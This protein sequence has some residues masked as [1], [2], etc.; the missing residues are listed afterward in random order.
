MHAVEDV[1]AW[2]T[3]GEEQVG[4]KPKAWLLDPQRNR[5]LWKQ[6]RL[7][8]GEHWA[9]VVAANVAQTLGIPHAEVRLAQR[10]II[11]GSIARDFRGDL[12]RR[13]EL[14]LGNTLLATKIADYDRRAA[15][16][17]LH[18]VDAVLDLL[19]DPDIAPPPCDEPL[20]RIATARGF[21]V[22][23]LLLDALVGNTDRHHEN[24]GLIVR[25][26]EDHV[27]ASQ[28]MQFGG[29]YQDALNRVSWELAPTF[30]H[31][32]SLGR[33]ID[34]ATRERR[35]AGRDPRFT[36]EHYCARGRSPLFTATSPP[37]QLT[38]R[39]ALARAIEILPEAGACW[40]DRLASVSPEQ[41]DAP[42]DALPPSVASDSARGFAK[43]VLASNRKHLLSLRSRS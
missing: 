16:P 29:N 11:I 6:P 25:R 9:E 22:G 28:T 18:T 10:G 7:G 31:A 24:W 2:P 34:D 13:P 39:E 38:T 35:L 21:F 1:T 12:G 14:V 33:D 32:S 20:S 3:H 8:T 23:Y 5:W 40:L 17:P 41:F 4:S 36:V 26:W 15:K 43:A 27:V 37:R 19:T 30:D 42:V